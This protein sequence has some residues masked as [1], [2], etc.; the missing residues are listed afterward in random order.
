MAAFCSQNTAAE[1]DNVK[2]VVQHTH[3][4]KLSARTSLDV[5]YQPGYRIITTCFI[6]FISGLSQSGAIE[7]EEMGSRGG[8]GGDWHANF[9]KKIH[10]Y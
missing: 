2:V 6:C 4:N 10:S 5:M 9:K 8:A 1:K 7:S 3:G